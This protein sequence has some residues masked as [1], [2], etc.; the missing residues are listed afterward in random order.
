LHFLLLLHHHLA[1]LVH[2]VPRCHLLLSDKARLRVFAMSTVTVFI[3]VYLL[4]HPLVDRTDGRLLKIF[5]TLTDL[6]RPRLMVLPVLRL[7]AMP[8]LVKMR[9]A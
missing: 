3:W 4:L 9:T 8:S 2:L 1:L 7:V 5:P 6:S